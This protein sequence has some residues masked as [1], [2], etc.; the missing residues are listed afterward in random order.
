MLWH[1]HMHKSKIDEIGI[2]IDCIKIEDVF[3][4]IE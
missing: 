3:L 1:Y 2:L 4:S